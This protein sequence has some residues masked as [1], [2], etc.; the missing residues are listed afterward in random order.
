MDPSQL[1][2]LPRRPNRARVHLIHGNDIDL[3]HALDLL[4][5]RNADLI[6]GD[7]VVNDSY[8]FRNQGKYLYNGKELLEI[9]DLDSG[10][11]PEEFQAAIEFPPR[12]WSEAI[13]EY[14][15][16]YFNYAQHLP[17]MGPEN[18]YSVR[19]PDHKYM[20]VLPFKNRDGRV[21]YIINNTQLDSDPQGSSE[22]Q[23]FLDELE[24]TNIFGYADEE[25]WLDCDLH[26]ILQ[27][28]NISPEDV[29]ILHVQV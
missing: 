4:R 5:Q 8:Y 21:Y 18:V 23:R 2:E 15:G 16:V 1:A 7:V 11:V 19:T 27:F 25:M 17:N 22:I 29:L 14:P 26:S 24:T 12:Y 6:R 9:E 13:L 28:N 3:R 10:I 20:L